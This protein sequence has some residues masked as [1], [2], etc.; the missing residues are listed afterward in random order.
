MFTGIVTGQ[1]TLVAIEQGAED[2]HLIFD[3]PAAVLLDA[4][5][6]DSMCIAGVCLTML[7]PSATG[8]RVDVSAETLSRTT[9]GSLAVGDRVN[10]EPALRLGDRLGGHLVSGHV[11]GLATLVGRES[12]GRSER[13]RF[14][15]PAVL[16][17]YLAVKGSVC[18]DGVSLTVNSV[19]GRRFEVCVIPHTLEMTSLGELRPGD[20]ANIEIDQVARYL[21]RLLGET[22]DT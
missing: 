15:V 19:E 17:R 8:F 5:A 16:Q 21:E 20:L 4:R 2:V 12:A 18:L 22:G 13:L 6:G 1:G 14:E 3:A 9:L 7:Q 11:D 10:L